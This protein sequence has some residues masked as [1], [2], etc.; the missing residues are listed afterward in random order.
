MK[1]YVYILESQKDYSFYIGQTQNS[2]SRLEKHN[3]GY[4]K[5][6]SFVD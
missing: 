2:K 6:T 1:Y 3:K 4:I 5:T